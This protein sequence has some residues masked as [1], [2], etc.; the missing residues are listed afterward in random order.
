[1]AEAG[2][3]VARERERDILYGEV[4]T[5]VSWFSILRKCCTSAAGPPRF[6]VQHHEGA[7][8]CP[9]AASLPQHTPREGTEVWM[10]R[11]WHSATGVVEMSTSTS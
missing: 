9:H 3:R 6:S 11:G 5:M 7:G 4:P 10:N 1:M 2:E 8:S